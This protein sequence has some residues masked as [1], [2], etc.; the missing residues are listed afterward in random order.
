[1]KV[2]DLNIEVGTKIKLYID[3]AKDGSGGSMGRGVEGEPENLIDVIWRGPIYNGT[4]GQ[5]DYLD[6]EHV[7]L[8]IS[9]NDILVANPEFNK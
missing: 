3:R 8:P 2:I 5:A 4:V 7:G 1:M 6:G 9:A